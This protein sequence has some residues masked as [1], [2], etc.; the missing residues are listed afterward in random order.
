MS[1]A[2]KVLFEFMSAILILAIVNRHRLYIDPSHPPLRKQVD[3]KGTVERERER[4]INSEIERE[5]VIE[6]RLIS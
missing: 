6:K 1:R 2:V 5:N 3:T 4:K